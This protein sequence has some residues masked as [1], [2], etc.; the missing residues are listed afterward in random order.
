MTGVI[1]QV[2]IQLPPTEMLGLDHSLKIQLITR[3]NLSMF[4]HCLLAMRIITFPP[5]IILWVMCVQ[6]FTAAGKTWH[7]RQWAWNT[8]FIEIQERCFVGHVE[9]KELQ[10]VSPLWPLCPPQD[11]C[12]IQLY[13]RFWTAW[14]HTATIKSFL[15]NADLRF[16]SLFKRQYTLLFH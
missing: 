1:E 4:F 2:I 3:D 10:H 13:L 11:Q 9:V 12:V 6:T 7:K 16:L 8:A 5:Q 15:K 14:M